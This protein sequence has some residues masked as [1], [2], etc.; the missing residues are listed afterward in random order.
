MV[1]AEEKGS[2]LGKRVSEVVVWR[3][4]A[5]SG[6][7]R[8]GFATDVGSMLWILRFETVVVWYSVSF[9]D[10]ASCNAR[11]CETKSVINPRST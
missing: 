3:A 9:R 2:V 7:A 8:S 1:R 10:S 5:E 4:R 11:A 6:C